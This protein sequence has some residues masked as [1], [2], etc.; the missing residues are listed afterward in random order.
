MHNGLY[1]VYCIKPEKEE[2]ISIRRVKVLKIEITYVQYYR[3]LDNQKYL[4]LKLSI[5][6]ITSIYCDL[7]AQKNRLGETV[8]LS[9]HN[10]CFG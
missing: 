1:Q 3:P 8:L 5:F 6:S 2:S 9:T 4:C 10:I 7:G